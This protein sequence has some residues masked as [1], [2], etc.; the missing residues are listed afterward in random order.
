MGSPHSDAGLC[1]PHRA[2]ALLTP[3]VPHEQA[4]G[5][6]DT[7]SRPPA[8]PWCAIH[9]QKA[10]ARGTR[11]S[12]PRAWPRAASGGRASLVWRVGRV[13]ASG[14]QRGGVS[15]EVFGEGGERSDARDVR[16][17]AR[18]P[19]MGSPHSDAGLCAPHRAPA[20]L[21]PHVPHE[22]AGG[23][24]DTLSRP[25]AFPWCAIH[26]QK[27]GARG[28]SCKPAPRIAEGSVGWAGF[29]CV[30]RGSGDRVRP[31]ARRRERGGFW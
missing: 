8:F 24:D 21:T 10:G 29:P 26:T 27:A 22:Q 28:Y 31:A 7:L 20:L 13:I 19:E 5:L 9:T 23:L 25:P 6:D 18:A 12:P 17:A 14:Q 16:E 11:A 30:A 4:G 1:A 3:H 2:P 15:E